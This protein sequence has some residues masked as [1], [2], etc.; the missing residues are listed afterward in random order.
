[1]NAKYT[2]KQISERRKVLCLTQKDLAARL[3]VTDKAVGKWERGLNFPDLSTMED[4]AAALE[5]TPAVLLGLEDAS[6]EEIVNSMTELSNDQLADAH[7]D[8]RRAGWV[9]VGAAALLV[10]TYMLFGKDVRK[11]QLAYQLLHGI[12]L[13]AI[14]GGIWLLVKYGEIRKFTVLDWGFL[15]GFAIPILIHLGIQFL[16]GRSPNEILSLCLAA[17]SACFGQ[18]LIC[19]I[20][21]PQPMKALPPVLLAGYACW[22]VLKGSLI[23]E[24]IA[25]AIC[26]AVIC[27]LYKIN[28]KKTTI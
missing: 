18:L 22:L 23:P 10:L 11:T 25:A 28:Q 13:L 17:M 1:M 24:I 5:T 20:L 2:G 9:S 3:H 6:R 4:L 26:C 14:I 21:R 16:T 8:V 27:L 19:R 7:R 12:I 15:Y